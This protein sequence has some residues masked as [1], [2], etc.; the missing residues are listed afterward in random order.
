MWVGPAGSDKH[1]GG[2]VVKEIFTWEFFGSKKGMTHCGSI[3]KGGRGFLALKL[4]IESYCLG[5]K[6]RQHKAKRDGK[7]T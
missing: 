1:G 2:V 4:W 3:E 7:K 6:G 5:Y